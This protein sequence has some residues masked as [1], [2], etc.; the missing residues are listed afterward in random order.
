[1]NGFSAAWYETSAIN[2]PDDVAIAAERVVA[3]SPTASTFA[4][5][6]TATHQ[7]GLWRVTP[8]EFLTDHTGYTEYIHVLAG[9][10]RLIDDDGAVLELWPGV[11]VLMQPGWKGR[12][13]VDATITKVYTV[14]HA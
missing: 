2:W 13:V 5:E 9:A 3:G 14:I 7:V 1:M 11:T 4:I 8:G 12:W 10:G 6:D